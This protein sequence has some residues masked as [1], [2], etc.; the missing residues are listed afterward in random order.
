MFARLTHGAKRI[1]LGRGPIHVVL[2]RAMEEMRK[3]RKQD[4]MIIQL[5][6]GTSR[7]MDSTTFNHAAIQ[8]QAFA[9]NIQHDHFAESPFPGITIGRVAEVMMTPEYQAYE[10]I[11]QPDKRM[12]LSLTDIDEIRI[13]YHTI[14]PDCFPHF[15]KWIP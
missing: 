6:L 13:A 7:L 9:Q 14:A 8:E 5:E 12:G 3:I 11:C 15:P 2:T 10:A 4:E 1:S